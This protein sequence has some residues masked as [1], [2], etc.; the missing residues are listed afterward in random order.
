MKNTLLLLK[1]IKLEM[2]KG[3]FITNIKEIHRI[4]R[5]YFENPYSNKLGNLD[6]MDKL[7]DT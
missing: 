2:K 3:R 1:L 7:L 6:E 4:I 5:D